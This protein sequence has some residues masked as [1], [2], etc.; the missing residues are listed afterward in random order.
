MALDA[1]A[2][3][4]ITQVIGAVVDVQFDGHLPAI[5]NALED[6]QQRPPAGARGGA[7]PGRE[8]RA[9]HR[10]GRHR[11]PRAR[12]PVTNTGAPIQAPVG[13]ATLGRILNVIGDPVDEKGPVNA[14]ESRP[15]HRAPRPSPSSRPSP[16]P[17]DR[18]QG[19]RPARPLHQGRQDRPVRR[20]RRGQDGAHPGAHQQHRQGALG[21]LGVRRRGRAHP[22]G[23]RPLPRDQDRRHQHGRPRE[24]KVVLVYG[25][26]NEPPGARARVALT[27][28]TIAEYFR[29]EEGR[30]CCS[31]WTT[32]SASPR[33][34][35]RCPRSSAASPPPWVT[36][37]RSP[38]RWARCRSASPP[39]TRARSPRCRR[40]T[41]PPTT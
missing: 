26:M 12:R 38:P 36:S 23:Q 10:H 25:Q 20:R 21:L 11:R 16:D 30:T 7:A 31:S 33:R 29:D 22:R 8:H 2:H 3:G 14:T 13:N 4:K 6:R 9:L 39:P 24:A 15:I 28:L 34:A 1:T 40:S 5:L 27:A 35:P 37:P 19:H 32:S 18:H 41:C 17:R